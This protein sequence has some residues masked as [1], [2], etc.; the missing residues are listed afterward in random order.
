MID[1]NNTPRKKMKRMCDS[2]MTDSTASKHYSSGIEVVH[3]RSV[4]CHL[5]GWRSVRSPRLRCV[6]AQLSSHVVRNERTAIGAVKLLSA[7]QSAVT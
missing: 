7:H 4:L 6:C 5:K 3:F 1:S 2:R